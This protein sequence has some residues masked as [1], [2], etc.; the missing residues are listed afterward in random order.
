MRRRGADSKCGRA[1]TRPEA[2]A[3]RTGRKDGRGG[4]VKVQPEV[5]ANA[6]GG[7]D[8][9]A[10]DAAGAVDCECIGVGT[11]CAVSLAVNG[12]R[13]DVRGLANKDGSLLGGVKAAPDEVLPPDDD[14]RENFQKYFNA[15]GKSGNIAMLSRLITAN[16][17]DISRYQT[18]IYSLFALANVDGDPRPEV[19][20]AISALLLQE[21]FPKD[22][23]FLDKYSVE[24]IDLYDGN[25]RG[26]D[27]YSQHEAEVFDL[28]GLKKYL[29]S[30]IIARIEHFISDP[31]ALFF[32]LSTIKNSPMVTGLSDT[33]VSNSRV[34]VICFEKLK[35]MKAYYYLALLTIQ[36]SAINIRKNCAEYLMDVFDSIEDLN[37]LRVLASSSCDDPPPPIVEKARARLDEIESRNVAGQGEAGGAAGRGIG[38][39]K[40]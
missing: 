1:E 2:A 27:K 18:V 39:K 36:A 34:A 11:Q 24:P 32:I 25:H 15:A 5:I 16:A 17:D 38:G 13:G 37:A 33:L 6:A 29:I 9:G 3:D 12:D 14:L 23:W 10:C 31:I 8:D 40:K 19:L 28:A 35:K 21:Y 26:S 30:F 7:K 22:G 4:G 20:S